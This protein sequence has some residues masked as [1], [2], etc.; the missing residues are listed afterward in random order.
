MANPESVTARIKR[1]K[2]AFENDDFTVHKGGIIQCGDPGAERV[3]MVATHKSATNYQT[4]EP[5]RAYY[6][7][8]APYEMGY[9]MGRLAEPDIDVM[10]EQFIDNVILSMLH[11]VTNAESKKGKQ[12]REQLLDTHKILIGVLRSMIRRR[13]MQKDASPELK[14]ELNG[15]YDGCKDAAHFENRTTKVKKNE[16]WVLNMG[17]DLL[18]SIVYTGEIRSHV[19]LSVRHW[20]M[21]V[22]CNAFAL[23]NAATKATKDHKGPFFGRDFM[24]STGKVFQNVACHVIYNPVSKKGSALSLPVV[25]MTAPGFVGSIAAM[26]SEGVAA[27]V[28]MIPAANCTSAEP[29]MNSLLMVRDCI[30]RGATLEDAKNRIINAQR[31]VSWDYILAAAGE[32]K[33]EDSACVVEAG[34]TMEKIPFRSYVQQVRMSLR[35]LLPKAAYINKHRSDT[36]TRGVMVRWPGDV[37]ALD[38][39]IKKFNRSLWAYFKKTLYPDAFDD[40]GYINKTPE[41]RNCP[42]TYY[43]APERMGNKD[44]ILAT[45]HWIH[46]ELRLCGM[47]TWTNNFAKDHMNDVQWRYDE[48]NFRIKATLDNGPITYAQARKLIDYLNPKE[49]PEYHKDNDKSEDG[50]QLVIN[51]SVSL[52]DLGE[53][54]VESHYGYYKDEWVRI[55]LKNYLN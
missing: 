23:L 53:R 49:F 36:D 27:G 55:Q 44:V 37:P 20:R 50:S 31:G 26:N 40:R 33:G 52:F 17:L 39:Y 19:P 29:G 47:K 15:I 42:E 51:G 1:L 12:E 24:F 8:G 43:F 11:S 14:Q 7:E 41:E 4:K 45:N 30:E 18:L 54:S 22:A 3:G 35:A 10:T 9:L 13:G 2:K 5:K 34:A 46:P 48:L 32:E 21:P 6:V 38:K 28:D 25:S 16:L